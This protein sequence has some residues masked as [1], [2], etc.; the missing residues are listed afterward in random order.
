MEKRSP[1]RAIVL[2]IIYLLLCLFSY[3]YH[4]NRNDFD[5]FSAIFIGILTVPWGLGFLLIMN[6]IIYPIFKFELTSFWI[7]IVLLVS[8]SINT[9]L[10]YFITD[11]K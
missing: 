7:N 3:L 4:V 1:K 5:K 2:V 10:I 8:V 6:L 11:K 9:F